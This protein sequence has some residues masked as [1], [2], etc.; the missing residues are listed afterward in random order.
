[1][2]PCTTLSPKVS[3][4]FSLTYSPSDTEPE[5]AAALPAT[6]T[7]SGDSRKS[8]IYHIVQSGVVLPP[9]WFLLYPGN[10][11]STGSGIVPRQM[12]SDDAPALQWGL[13]HFP[14]WRRH[15]E[16]YVLYSY[17]RWMHS[18]HVPCRMAIDPRKHAKACF[19][20]ATSTRLEL[21][22]TQLS[23]DARNLRLAQQR[24]S[25][26]INSS[27][28]SRRDEGLSAH[29]R[30]DQICSLA[31]EYLGS[32]WIAIHSAAVRGYCNKFR[33]CR[34]FDHQQ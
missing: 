8:T 28:A 23:L 16:R 31:L 11:S 2:F 4:T 22:L 12:P 1:M 9:V 5:Q 34:E 24:S 26:N 13:V 21:D 10:L 25:P 18:D 19:D 15:N 20:M 33:N 7:E 14:D 27:S 6:Q 30:P 3:R 29:S 17:D 32:G